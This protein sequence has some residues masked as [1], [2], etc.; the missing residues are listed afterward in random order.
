MR[1]SLVTTAG[2]AD[3]LRIGY[4]DRP[5]LFELDIRKPVDL[6]QTA[7]EID[8]RIDHTGRVLTALDTDQVR[9]RLEPLLAGGVSSLAVCLMN[10]YRNPNHER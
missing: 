5:E 6:Y 9:A 7:V 2:L 8:E 4:Q 1:G 3:V 10:S